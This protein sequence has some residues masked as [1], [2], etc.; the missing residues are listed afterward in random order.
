[1]AI[2]FFYAVAAALDGAA[3]PWLFGALI[4]SGSAARFSAVIF[5]ARH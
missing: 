3:A 1:L 2:A 4:G 5:S